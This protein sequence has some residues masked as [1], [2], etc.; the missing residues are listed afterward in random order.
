[1][2]HRTALYC[3]LGIVNNLN[4]QV[5]ALDYY[6]VKKNILRKNKVQN[7]QHPSENAGRGLALALASYIVGTSQINPQ[8]HCN[9][10]IIIHRLH[11][12]SCCLL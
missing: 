11:A 3:S 12:C 9:F 7:E 2:F 10:L 4:I 8:F 1:M 5:L 6:G